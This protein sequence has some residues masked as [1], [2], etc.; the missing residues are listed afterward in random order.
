MAE[1]LV[2]GDD[3]RCGS[4]TGKIEM[5]TIYVSIR[6]EAIEAVIS[7]VNRKDQL[8]KVVSR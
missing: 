5:A 6:P 4:G 3:I 2:S 7:T 1:R 8:A